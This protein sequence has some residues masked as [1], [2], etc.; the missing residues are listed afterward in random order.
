MSLDIETCNKGHRFLRGLGRGSDG[1]CSA[2]TREYSH[3]R[4]KDPEKRAMDRKAQARHNLNREGFRPGDW[5]IPEWWNLAR[6]Q[7]ELPPVRLKGFPLGGY[8]WPTDERTIFVRELVDR[9]QDDGGTSRLH[10]HGSGHESTKQKQAKAKP[11]PPRP[12]RPPKEKS[13]AMVFVQGIGW[14]KEVT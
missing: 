10:T 8:G 3:N 7:E 2:C 13:E 1:S 14:V 4:R 11:K 12:K 6:Q 5:V 9:I